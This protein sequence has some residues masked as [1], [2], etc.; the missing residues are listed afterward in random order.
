MRKWP[1]KVVLG[2]RGARIFARF[3][4]SDWSGRSRSADL[5]L[6]GASLSFTGAGRSLTGAIVDGW[7]V[8]ERPTR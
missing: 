8:P 4:S 2:R 6:V 3:G 7:L 1:G 5:S